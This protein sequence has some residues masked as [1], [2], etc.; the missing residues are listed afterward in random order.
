MDHSTP[1]PTTPIPRG[2][3]RLWQPRRAVFWLMLAFNA[4][5]SVMGGVLRSDLL[6]PAGMAVVGV[7]AL[8]NALA[9]MWLM[10]RMLKGE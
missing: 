9:G 1:T 6:S 8:G 5:S 2:W 3:R 4:L 7:L 10:L